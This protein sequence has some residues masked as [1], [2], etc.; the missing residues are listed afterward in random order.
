MSV[1]IR[2]GREQSDPTDPTGYN[3]RACRALIYD[4]LGPMPPALRVLLNVGQWRG[5]PHPAIADDLA[6]Y[7]APG[8]QVKVQARD[9]A[10]LNAWQREL[11]AARTRVTRR[12]AE[13]GHRGPLV[14]WIGI[15][16]RQA[17]MDEWQDQHD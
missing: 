8:A 4:Q 13:A 6:E 17:E 3:E 5:E 12:R 11:A 14:D 7:L 1:Y 10:T 15:R 9:V 16:Q 2:F